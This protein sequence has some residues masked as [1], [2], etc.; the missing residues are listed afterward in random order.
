MLAE[1][2]GQAEVVK[3]TEFAQTLK[4][5]H[6]VLVNVVPRNGDTDAGHQIVLAKTF[7]RGRETWFEVIDSAEGPLKRLHMSARELDLLIHEN[8]VAF[9]PAPGATPALLR[10]R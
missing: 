5:G 8:G 2:F 7:Q 9:R 1:A 3:P 4:A 10:T 6:P